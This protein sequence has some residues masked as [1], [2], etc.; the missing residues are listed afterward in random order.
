MAD[1]RELAAELAPE[2]SWTMATSSGMARV[3]KS[4]GISDR[5]MGTKSARPSSMARRSG[6]P[7]KRDTDWKE[8]ARSGSANGAGPAVCR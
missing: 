2:V 5:K 8:L 1:R 4:L 6:A 7:V 3:L